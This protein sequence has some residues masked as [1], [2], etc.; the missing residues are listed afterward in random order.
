ML[1]IGEKINSSIPK[2]A[3]AMERRDEAFLR[4]L[5]QDQAAA[6]AHFI[7]VNAGTFL[8]EEVTLLPWLVE[9]VQS[10]VDVPLCVDSPSAA[11]LAAALAVVK[12]KPLV[13]SLSLEP[14]RYASVIQLVHQYKTSIVALCMDE[15]GIPKT[16]RRR[17]EIADCL[18]QRLTADGVALED[19]FLDVMLQPIAT[20][21]ESGRVALETVAAIRTAYPSVHIV[22]GL[23]NVSFGLPLRRLLNQAFAVALVSHGM[24]T[25]IIDPLDARMMSLQRALNALMGKDE[26]FEEYLDAHRT[27]RLGV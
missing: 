13:N 3:E 9:L 12:Q 16:A 15:H 4:K 10:T 6:G 14:D 22:C 2:V 11:A 1:F 21:G 24:D 8:Q 23:G 25:L 18:V 19:I 17:V 27:G 20:D 7:D 5:A 26:Y